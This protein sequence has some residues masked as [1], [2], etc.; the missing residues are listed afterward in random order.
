ML[1]SK[2]RGG[3]YCVGLS[4]KTAVGYFRHH[5][6]PCDYATNEA[7]NRHQL[8]LL[9]A[10]IDVSSLCVSCSFHSVTPEVPCIPSV[11]SGGDGRL[12]FTFSLC[13][14]LSCIFVYF[15]HCASAAMIPLLLIDKNHVRMFTY[16]SM[17][18]MD[19]VGIW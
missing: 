3:V 18:A 13:C 12:S 15:L 4:L 16:L 19:I 2:T 11:F 17:P 8:F 14:I 5:F 1:M 7:T 6:G 9:N 10:L